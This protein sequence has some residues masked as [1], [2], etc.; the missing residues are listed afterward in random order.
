MAQ[1]IETTEEKPTI[2]ENIV[3]IESET[4]TETTNEVSPVDSDTKTNEH[5]KTGD[6]EPKATYKEFATKEEHQ[7]YLNK[8]LG[9]L[10]T[11]IKSLED[12]KT[13]QSE[14]IKRLTNELHEAK[15]KKKIIILKSK[16][17]EEN[18]KNK[19]DAPVGME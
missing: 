13:K 4:E 17:N 12:S 6:H 16:T 14:E 3:K 7:E 19:K 1:E 11:K 9:S 15:N 10:K 5:G 2:T 18:N 8:K